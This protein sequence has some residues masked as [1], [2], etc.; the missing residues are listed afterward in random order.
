MVLGGD[1]SSGIALAGANV[2]MGE[3][4]EGRQPRSDQDGILTAEEIAQLDLDGCRL[5]V[6]SACETAQ[7]RALGGEGVQGL[8]LGAA[9]AGARNQLS[10]LWPVDDAATVEIME[11]F[12]RAFLEGRI[13]EEA[14][15]EAQR[16]HFAEWRSEKGLA[17]ALRWAAPFVCT[18][19]EPF[20]AAA[21]LPVDPARERLWTSKLRAGE[22]GWVTTVNRAAKI[23]ITGFQPGTVYLWSKGYSEE[24]EADEAG[25]ASGEGTLLRL[26]DG[27]VTH[28]YEGTMHEGRFVG[29][30]RAS[31]RTGDEEEGRE[32][33]W[34]DG[35]AVR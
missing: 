35:G 20:E 3:W 1:Y 30:V 23:W 31:D 4:R 24:R 7:G 34:P 14:L 27:K 6:M 28:R 21:A 13:P 29:E 8:T 5:V 17:T 22:D 9:V 16:N 25:F 15:I 26:R 11:S 33:T 10:T 18:T 19:T 32:E 2:T 12:Y